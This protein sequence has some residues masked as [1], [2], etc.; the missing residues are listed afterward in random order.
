MSL[1]V[2][3]LDLDG[4][5]DLVVGEHN[6][7]APATS[8]LIVYE[9]DGAGLFW[10]QHVVYT[11][12]EHH[13]GAQ[14]FDT[15]DDGDLDI[16]SIGWGHNRVAIYENLALDG[17]VNQTPQAVAGADVTSGP[18]PLTVGFDGAGSSDPDGTI[19]AYEW[20][21]GDGTSDTGA[22]PSH[23]YPAPGAYLV[24]LRVTDD[25]GSSDPTTMLITVSE[26]VNGPPVF[27]QDLDDR[28][29]AEGALI[30]IDAG[31]SDP[32]SDPLTFAATGLPSGLAIDIRTGEI[33]G[34]ISFDAAATSP[35]TVTVTVTDD[36][37][38]DD[39]DTFT[40]T[41]TNTNRDPVFDQD[42]GD[43][44]DA[45]GGT[46]VP[47]DA[48]ATDPDGDPLTYTATG[49]PPGLAIDA[50]TGEI[51]G[52]ITA[53]AAAESPYAVTVTVTDDIAVDDTD[54]FT[55]TVTGTVSQVKFA[56]FG[57]YGV[58]SSAE[59][60]VADLVGSKNVDFVITTGDNTYGNTPIDD[61]V[62]KYYASYI[63]AYVGIYGPGSGPNRFFPSAGNHDYSDG[64]GITAYESYFTLPGAGIANSS[65]N[66]LYYDF[67]QG[68]VH[69]FALDSNPTSVGGDDAQR[70]PTS[71]QGI[72]L[73][74]RLAASTSPWNIVY[75]HHAP[76]SS[77]AAHGTTEDETLPGSM[78][79]PFEAWGV[80]AV[81]VGH[82]HTYERIL[83][84]D[85]TDGTD[86]PYFVTGAGGQSLHSFN[87]TPE[88]GSV[89]RY[90]ADHGTM[91]VTASETAITFEFW[92]IAGGGTLVD[93][94]TIDA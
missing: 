80:T 84:D 92:S 22:S 5:V 18:A 42:V 64:G 8:R 75:F 72:W 33:S 25:G 31:A 51:T 52:T 34:S 94:Y 28:S 81:L 78:K 2:A 88:P 83:K 11:G 1:D 21:F 35:Y 60:N 4:D 54:T 90:N 9:N 58:D 67:V 79:W 86:L 66:E 61:N 63:G 15:D 93:T 59:L 14:L 82:D 87:S 45:E 3:D 91:I 74:A 77:S 32:D 68:P 71:A 12:D 40:W 24:T 16:V 26:P 29:D 47:I 39:T 49:L 41:V 38:V 30:I 13:D 53:G 55:W 44:A 43:Q 62:G 50:E 85:N 7:A 48:G 19:T 46:V 6:L 23:T 56:A 73:E 70:S 37:A 20:D 10:I 76:Y 57:D 17:P 89:V 36:I 65:G 69:F 27:D